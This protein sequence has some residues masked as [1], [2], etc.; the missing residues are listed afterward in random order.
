[1]A[2]RF[3]ALVV[4][5]ACFLANAHA[6]SAAQLPDAPAPFPNAP[7]LRNLPR[8]L[9]HDQ[10]GI[11]TS[12]YRASDGDAVMGILFI[13][14]AGA[15]GSEDANIMQHHFLNQTTAN[16]ANTASTG[17]TGLIAA[18]PIAYFGIGHLT[19]NAEAEQTGMLAGEAMIDGVAVNEVFKI[20]SRRERPTLDNAKGRFFQPGV[21]FES[22]FASNHSVLAWTSATVIASESD[23]FLVKLAA[24]G[25]ATGVSATRVIGR[26][27]F[28][29]DVYIGSA[30]GWM[31][32]RYVLRH[33]TRSFE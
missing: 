12:P 19:H 17:L 10:A 18:A 32:G 9:L 6:Q 20:A 11:W 26:D 1:M 8:N 14:S 16:H 27:H 33:H 24:Y 25:L 30:V 31:I 28:P 7:T 4:A 22:S 3:F 21:G 5:G 2:R 13:A 23:H 15:L 29:S